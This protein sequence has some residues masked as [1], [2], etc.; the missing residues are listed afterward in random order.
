MSA[1]QRV[2]YLAVA[3]RVSSVILLLIAV[4]L[5]LA[6][7]EIPPVVVGTVP[8]DLVR[9]SNFNV[10]GTWITIALDVAAMVFLWRSAADPA[11][12]RRVINTI[13]N[14]FLL[15]ALRA[16]FFFPFLSEPQRDQGHAALIFALS[17]VLGTI[18]WL[19]QRGLPTG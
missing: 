18:L 5:L 7:F 14:L 15:N 6:I 2:Q 12:H 8:G 17:A 11:T 19:L 16:A 10:L 4:L 9:G 13:S 1:V 3:L